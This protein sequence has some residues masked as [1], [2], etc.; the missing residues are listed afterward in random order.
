MYHFMMD[1]FK[2]YRSRL[3][4]ILLVH[5]LLEEIPLKMGLKTV[6]PPFVL[7]Y[8]NGITP[9]D[10]GIS[11]FVFLAGGHFTIHT[12]SYREAFFVDLLYPGQFD[13]NALAERIKDAFPAER[14][15]T[16]S[17]E[18]N[19]KESFPRNITIDE[20]MDFGPHL[21]LDFNDYEGPRTLEGLFDLFDAMP[22]KIDM[23]PIIRPY[24]QKNNIDGKRVFSAL[25]MIA[26][27]HISL[28]YFADTKQAYLDLFSCRFFDYDNVIAKL[29][30]D[31]GG[32]ASN[33]VLIPR[34]SKYRQYRNVSDVQAA[35]SR[36]WLKNI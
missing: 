4:D 30:S 33:K 17:V 3:D 19:R 35:R 13:V 31:L 9:E 15:T 1:A 7:P 32:S 16:Y 25:T 11:A 23:T 2:G 14:V 26:E 29:E 10:C 24:V 18:R 6:M 28:H 34:G 8:Y 22:Y 21:F 20:S 27:S 36:T 5:E 12:F